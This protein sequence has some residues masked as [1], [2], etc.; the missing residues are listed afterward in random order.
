MRLPIRLTAIIAALSMQ[1]LVALASLGLAACDPANEPVATHEGGSGGEPL[2]SCSCIANHGSPSMDSAAILAIAIVGVESC[3]SEDPDE[4]ERQSA[5]LP[6]TVGSDAAG[7]ELE[8]Y[9]FCSDVCPDRGKVGI[10]LVGIDDEATCCDIGGTPIIDEAWN[11]YVG[12][13]PSSLEIEPVRA[14]P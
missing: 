11:N 3:F 1:L 5:C 2:S 7:R 10:G 8:A 12:C 13:A 14:C 9:Y 4:L 6:T